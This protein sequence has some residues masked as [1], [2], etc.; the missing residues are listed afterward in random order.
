MCLDP[1]YDDA[2]AKHLQSHNDHIEKLHTSL[3]WFNVQATLLDICI[4]FHPVG[5][6]PYVILEIVDK[7]PFWE[8]RVH[9]KKKIDYIIR[10]NTFCDNLI[11]KRV[12]K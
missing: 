1:W 10:I 5:L 7:F 2:Y 6:P 3:K 8:T 4:A 11:E 9:R 12:A